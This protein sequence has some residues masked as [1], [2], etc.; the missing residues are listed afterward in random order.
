MQVP[1]AE[2]LQRR[3]QRLSDT[4]RRLVRRGA[5]RNISRLLAKVRPEDVATVLDALTPQ[6]QL[7]IFRIVMQE[8]TDTAGEVLLD[9]D[10]SA[11]RELLTRLEHEE[12]AAAVRTLA[13]DDAVALVDFVPEEQRE[14]ILALIKGRENRELATQLTYAGDSAGRIMNTVFFSLTEETTVKE[15]ISVLREVGQVEMVLYLYVTRANGELAGVTSLRRLLISSTDTP[16]SEIMDSSVIKVT[17]ETDQEEVA[18]LASKYDLLAI[19][20][21]DDFNRLVGI[22]TVDDVIDIVQE[23][24]EEDFLRL[25]GTSE[26]ELLYRERAWRVARIRLPWLL[27]NLCGLFVTGI[28]FKSFEVTLEEALFVVFFAP[29]IMGMGGNIGAQTTTITVR[30]LATGRLGQGSGRIPAFLWQQFRVGAILGVTCGPIAALGAVAM[31]RN[32][33]LGVVV[34]LSLF[35]GMTLASLNGSVVPLL[36]DRLGVDPAVAAG[37][38]VTTTSDMVGIAVYFGI[39]AVMIQGLTG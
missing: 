26:D 16:L 33:M 39:A 3:T 19:P 31:E 15:A 11:A 34:A 5:V 17:T 12:I 6:E 25:V 10:P 22:V 27:I 18:Q 38:M 35:V 37:P 28:I 36:F 29:V 30:G 14:E 1:D 7:T 8:Y 4:V 24:A 2:A 9:M 32:P 20:V 13:I 21:T 23:E